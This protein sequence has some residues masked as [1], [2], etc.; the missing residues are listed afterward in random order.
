MQIQLKSSFSAG[1][2]KNLQ[3]EPRSEIQHLADN[4]NLRHQLM[5]N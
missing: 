1:I 5:P 3:K 2:S 4:T